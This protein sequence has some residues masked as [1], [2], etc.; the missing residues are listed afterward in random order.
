MTGDLKIKAEQLVERTGKTVIAIAGPTASGKTA[1]AIQLAQHFNTSI[2]SF[3]S[4]QCYREL[5]IGVA[6][7]SPEELAACPHYFIATHSIFEKVD[8]AVFE[9]Y[10]LQIL[11]KL[12]R[13]NDVVIAAGGTGLYLKA[14][15]DGLDLIPEIP[16]ATRKYVR[17]NYVASGMPWLHAELTEKDPQYSETGEMQNPQRM[18]RALEVMLATGN[19]IRHYQRKVKNERPFTLKPVVLQMNKEIL[20]ER[21]N[22]RTD[23]MMDNGLLEEVKSLYPH[24]QLNALQTVGYKELFDFLDG[25]LSLEEAVE[26]I[27]IHTRQYAKRQV[28]FFKP[29]DSLH[30]I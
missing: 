15:M 25:K 14:L 6:R 3:D 1:A 17:E 20:H 12:F 23:K 18:M 8:A 27:K 13:E 21:I 11:D 22:H 26:R 4:R 28:T 9:N 5:N 16:A 7:P 30:S 24:K 2:L 19:S 29:F 10:A